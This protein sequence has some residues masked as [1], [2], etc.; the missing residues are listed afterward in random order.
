MP[1]NDSQ[2]P[3]KPE[4][5]SAPNKRPGVRSLR[6]IEDLRRLQGRLIKQF[7]GGELPREDFKALVYASGV[8]C[9][10]LKH[11][12]P[13][14]KPPEWVSELVIVRHNLDPAVQEQIDSMNASILP[15]PEENAD[16]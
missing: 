11:L 1:K 13:E 4:S 12:E 7:M 16:V 10:T 15:A 8:L 6:T 3:A 14:P 9:Q 5:S 2:Q